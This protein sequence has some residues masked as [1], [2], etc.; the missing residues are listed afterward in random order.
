MSARL[1]PGMGGGG[2]H[3]RNR[4]VKTNFSATY[5][6]RSLDQFNRDDLEVGD[7]IILPQSAFKEIKRL[8]LPLPLVF[9]VE[10]A[11][12]RKPVTA[13]NGP[14]LQKRDVGGMPS[15]SRKPLNSTGRSA[16]TS[17]SS[18]SSATSKQPVVGPTKKHQYCGVMEF[19]A[20]EGKCFMPQ[21]MMRNLKLRQGG[22][23]I[24]TTTQELE[25]GSLVRFQPHTTN[26]IDLAANFGPREIMEHAMK[27]YSAL[28]DKETIL[29]ECAGERHYLDV[30]EVKPNGAAVLYGDLDLE[31][32]FALPKDQEKK[33]GE[34]VKEDLFWKNES[35]EEGKSGRRPSS[36]RRLRDTIAAARSGATSSK[37]STQAS[38]NTTTIGELA[39]D[40]DR[41]QEELSK[42]AVSDGSV[43][44]GVD[45]GGV[46]SPPR[47]RGPS[48][49][50]TVSSASQSESIHWNTPGYTLTSPTRTEK[51]LVAAP[52]TD[53]LAET[54]SSFQNEFLALR[55]KAAERWQKRKAAE[56]AAQSP[57]HSR[58]STT[59]CNA[60]GVLSP[61]RERKGWFSEAADKRAAKSSPVGSKTINQLHIPQGRFV[62]SGQSLKQ[63]QAQEHSQNHSFFNHPGATMS[64]G[65]SQEPT[66]MRLGGSESKSGSSARKEGRKKMNGGQSTKPF[67]GGTGIL[68]RADASGVENS[69]YEEEK[70]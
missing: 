3:A 33:E 67:L 23:A 39:G 70:E 66:G 43:W 13:Q 20:T 59:K 68:G 42:L 32:D 24:L 22:Q 34:E 31:V 60:S 65:H 18:K 55:A 6:V 4:K 46:A 58:D 51:E 38:D 50:E 16:A 56:N 37:P 64:S 8:G 62:G 10:N 63:E 53:M 2:G 41:L 17:R 29:I 25:K 19:T 9:E 14:Q 27:K 57:T 35:A 48:T 69:K 47:S 21:W 28:S 44:K 52:Q 45:L 5:E 7:K 54:S 36:A 40:P 11:R 49:Q 26:F 15:S 61:P 12:R 1:Y 30:L